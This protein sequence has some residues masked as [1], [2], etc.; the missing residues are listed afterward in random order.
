M[1]STTTYPT[2]ENFFDQETIELP[3]GTEIPVFTL[4]AI[5]EALAQIHPCAL[6][7][8]I[9]KCNDEYYQIRDFALVPHKLDTPAS[10]QGQIESENVLKHGDG[11][12][13][14]KERVA[15]YNEHLKKDSLTTSGLLDK[16][17]KPKCDVCTILKAISK[18]HPL[19]EERTVLVLPDGTMINFAL[20]VPR[21]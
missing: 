18:K 2:R 11:I 4:T 13:G 1:A 21:K 7:E 9:E 14:L 6:H 3:D 19:N 15:A 10:I 5:L 16:H 17:G 8:L 20:E 12:K